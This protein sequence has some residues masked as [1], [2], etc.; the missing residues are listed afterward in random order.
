MRFRTA[1]EGITRDTLPPNMPVAYCIYDSF[2]RGPSLGYVGRYIWNSP[3][4]TASIS[5][6][7]DVPNYLYRNTDVNGNRLSDQVAVILRSP[8]IPTRYI[9]SG[10]TDVEVRLIIGDVTA[11]V[12]DRGLQ[13]T[14]KEAWEDVYEAIYYLTFNKPTGLNNKISFNTLQGP[15]K[16]INDA[17]ADYNAAFG[18]IGAMGLH[19]KQDPINPQMVDSTGAVINYGNSGS[20]APTGGTSNYPSLIVRDLSTSLGISISTSDIISASGSTDSTGLPS[21]FVVA[22]PTTKASSAQIQKN[23][24]KT[25]TLMLTIDRGN[26]QQEALMAQILQLIDG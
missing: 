25:I 5:G 1:I 21:T 23:D 18:N 15:Q 9:K 7:T 13:L 12:N 17:I 6:E 16:L 10:A 26:T 20:G 4:T 2:K 19:S 24:S 8:Q 14:F 3:Q 22:V 11:F